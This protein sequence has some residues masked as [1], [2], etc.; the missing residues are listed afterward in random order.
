MEASTWLTH[1]GI[2]SLFSGDHGEVTIQNIF[3]I[4][5][6]SEVFKSY[7]VYLIVH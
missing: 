1:E 3:E 4:C 7:F 2:N 5:P 6:K